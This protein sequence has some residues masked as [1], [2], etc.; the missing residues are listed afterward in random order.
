MHFFNSPQVKIASIIALI[1]SLVGALADV[2]LLYNPAG[3]YETGDYHFLMDIPETRLLVGSYLGVFFIP[4][5]ILGLWHVYRALEPAGKKLV[6][7]MIFM[8]V[9]AIFPG[10]VY[11]G[12]IGFTATFLKLSPLMSPELLNTNM[13]FL[14]ALFEPLGATLFVLFT[15]ASLL[16]VYIVTT[17]ETHYC[18]WMAIANPFGIYMVFVLLYLSVPTIGNLLIPAGFNLAFFFFFLCSLLAVRED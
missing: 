1:A 9:Y 7:P 10:V 13:D 8:A 3:G 15:I 6:Y 17:K 11:H 2:L 12:T 14:K 4:L 5:E 18:K 16:F